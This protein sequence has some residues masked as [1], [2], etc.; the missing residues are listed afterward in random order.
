MGA[1][2]KTRE[3]QYYGGMRNPAL[4]VLF[5]AV[6]SWS[7]WIPS[8]QPLPGSI[9]HAF[10]L[11][12]GLMALT[13]GKP[14][15][16][17]DHGATWGNADGGLPTSVYLIS[18]AFRGDTVVAYGGGT[19][20][21]T[22]NAG[23]SWA[24]WNEGFE[25]PSENLYSIGMVAGDSTY[26]LSLDGVYGVTT[27]KRNPGSKWVQIFAPDGRWVEEKAVWL[28][29]TFASNDG[30]SGLTLDP[31]DSVWRL[32]PGTPLFTASA[33]FK[34]DY[35]VATEDNVLKSSD[36][37]RSWDT[38]YR[39]T[40]WISRLASTSFALVGIGFDSMALMN[41]ASSVPLRFLKQPEQYGMGLVEFGKRWVFLG[42]NATWY[43][44][45][46]GR[47]WTRGGIPGKGIFGKMLPTSQGVVMQDYGL[48]KQGW[49]SSDLVT[50]NSFVLPDTV[51]RGGI[52]TAA[53]L[54]HAMD[55]KG[56]WTYVDGKWV[57][58]SMALR[59]YNGPSLSVAWDGSRL[60]AGDNNRIHS[61][62][63][64]SRTWTLTDSSSL[65]YSIAAMRFWKDRLWVGGSVSSSAMY[66][67]R[68]LGSRAADGTWYYPENLRGTKVTAIAPT[69]KALWIG[70]DSCLYRFDDDKS[71]AGLAIGPGKSGG[72]VVALAARGDT[73]AVALTDGK[74]VASTDKQEV[75]L[76]L[77][78]GGTWYR[79][80]G[81]LALGFHIGPGRIVAASLTGGLLEWGDGSAV[82]ER[83]ASLR[84]DFAWRP[85]HLEWTAPDAR[86]LEILDARGRILSRI[87]VAP[88][89]YGIALPPA[90][91]LRIARL[92]GPSGTR[93]IA[94]PALR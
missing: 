15:L 2:R 41:P 3:C 86:S 67:N 46:S 7:A 87:D 65:V 26:V 88:G 10:Q 35:W 44:D 52:D 5:L 66:E 34:G 69:P 68:L 58:D 54:L 74:W 23:V 50:W 14:Y 60:W 82:P 57:R 1:M 70:T 93:A 81:S 72:N 40:P 27:W 51:K 16:S 33:W 31:S 43:S 76:S 61:K 84:R 63:L 38:L 24:K 92:T 4:S 28:G 83:A 12:K 48:L 36:S 42:E 89:T 56:K 80:E 17:T 85:G 62:A 6:S 53:G 30:K 55:Y 45:D 18:N 94:V 13:N 19:I 91:T 79:D 64:Q 29:K 78:G 71:H 22:C 32:S 49:I 73:I 59:G 9:Y 37:G 21:R 8:L 90:S 75:Y 11:S 20:W 39:T 25:A 77:D 47:K